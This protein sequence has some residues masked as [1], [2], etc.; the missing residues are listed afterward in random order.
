MRNN[1]F[2]GIILV[3]SLILR[4]VF[5]DTRPTGFTWDEAALGYNA[6]SLL[7]TGRDEH[8]QILPVVFKSFGDYKP[9]LYI[10]SAV[11]FIKALGLNEFT[12]R[13]PSAI[14]GTLLIL[15]VYLLTQLNAKRYSL[16]SAFTLAI[17]PW[18]IHFSRGAW[19]ANLALLLTTLGACLFIKRKY[20]L[21]ALFFGLTFWTYQ[22]AKMFSPL[23]LLSLWYVYRPQI[24]QIFKPLILLALI[25]APILFGLSTQSGRLKVFSVFSYSRRSSDIAEIIRQDGAAD[26][27]WIY[28]LFHAEIIDQSR[29]ILQRYLNHFSPYYLFIAGDW[30]NLRHSIPYYGYMHIPEILTFVIGLYSLLKFKISNYK[31]VLL[32]LL[33]A[34]IP[35]ALSRD[36]VSGIRSFPMVVPLS[37]ITGIGLSKIFSKKLLILFYSPA[38]ILFFVYYLDLYFIHAPNFIAGDWLYPYKPAMSLVREK[39]PEYRR[40]V[41]T[42][43]MGQPYIFTLFHL[44]IDPSQ[45]QKESRFIDSS[46]GDVGE[47]SVYGKFEFRQIFLPAE[48]DR[49]GT[50]YIGDEF[51]LNS[52]DIKNVTELN[53]VQ[54]IRLPNGKIA[55]RAVGFK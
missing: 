34:P 23:L 49:Q 39:L 13:V 11:P 4:L 53:F 21:S 51:E 40:I 43:K 8:G 12:T 7:Q 55:L 36:L 32:W 2:L 47:V 27:N 10:Y 6:Y 26:K 46:Q 35:S 3:V 42:S 24:K 38:L 44:Q 19:E 20:L 25:L 15:A 14:F 41:F 17:N 30:Q 37:I 29:G 54:D 5:L 52:I 33:I 22:G 16:F 45:F 9:G 31:L 28:Y 48:K 50:L 18:A 1:L